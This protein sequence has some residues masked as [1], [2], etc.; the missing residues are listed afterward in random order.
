[1]SS[2]TTSMTIMHTNI[3][4]QMKF[5]FM[6]HKSGNNYSTRVMKFLVGPCVRTDHCICADSYFSSINIVEEVEG[7]GLLITGVLKPMMRKYPVTYLSNLELVQCGDYKGQI[8]KS[9]DR[10]PDMMAFIWV[11]RDWQYFIANASSLDS[12]E[13]YSYHCW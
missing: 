3:F 5:L 10:H 6:N 12:G 11:D 4:H 13:L 2:I 7:M 1:M 9:N 8:S